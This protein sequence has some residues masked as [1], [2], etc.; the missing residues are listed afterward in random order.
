M[1][2]NNNMIVYDLEDKIIEFILKFIIFLTL[3][4]FLNINYLFNCNNII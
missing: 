3:I 2:V 1:E 4:N